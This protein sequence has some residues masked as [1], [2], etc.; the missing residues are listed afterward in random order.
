[1]LVGRTVISLLTAALLSVVGL[2]WLEPRLVYIPT[3][4]PDGQYA[5]TPDMVG[6]P[7]ERLDLTAA[8]GTRV[9]S[10]LLL[11]DAPDRPWLMYFHGNG[12]TLP[13]YLSFTQT[14]YE[15][16]LNVLMLEYRGY[17]ESEGRPSE[18]GLYQDARAAYD[19]LLARDVQPEQIIL[20]GFSLGTG[21]ATYLASQVEVAGMMLEAPYTSLADAARAAYGPLLPTFLMRNRF[22]SLA[23]IEDINVP[24]LVMHARS[25][26][27]IPFEQGQTLFEAANDPKTFVSLNGGH[28]SLVSDLPDDKLLQTWQVFIEDATEFRQATL[29]E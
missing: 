16:G 4:L 25:D 6:L 13:G 20:Y 29:D 14:L 8:D 5:T 15:L 3:P 17:G 22:E 19:A 10:W 1:M 7:Y 24:L 21:V 27:V 12:G 9:V 2:R 18:Q 28:N 23:R 11:Q 26:R